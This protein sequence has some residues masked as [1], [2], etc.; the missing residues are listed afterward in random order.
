MK[1]SPATGSEPVRI[2]VL[3]CADIARRRVLPAFAADPGSRVVAV[4]SR[5]GGRAREVADRFDCAAVTGYDRLI[6]DPGVEAVYVPLPVA[7]HAHWIERALRAGKHVLGEKPLT[8]DV[9]STR[10]LFGLAAAR[11]LVL[12]ENFM[13]PCHPLHRRVREL[14]AGGAIGELRS[15]TGEFAIPA[16]PPGDVRY[17]AGLGGGALL[18]I[19]VNPLLAARFF[20]G[21]ALTVCGA[22][23]RRHPVHGVDTGGAVLLAAPDGVTAQVVFGMEHAYRAGYELWGSAGRI[24]VERAYAPP[25]DHCPVIRVERPEGVEELVLHPEDQFLAAVRAFSHAVRQSRPPA[26]GPGRT[27]QPPPAP[28]APPSPSSPRSPGTP[29]TS[30]TRDGLGAERGLRERHQ[31]RALTVAR[32][33]A[34]VRA[35]DKAASSAAQHP[36]PSWDDP[37]GAL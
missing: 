3:G 10:R 19:A 7:L 14:L 8:G 25:A 12:A 26:R 15:F 1:G 30:Q 18:D 31:E 36:V 33:V 27:L 2:G 34:E 37:R 6:A 13:F 23:L 5:D 4:A 16:P 11:G 28:Q 22:R 35:A 29:Q 32:L 21:P 24:R 20:L 17:D 9:D